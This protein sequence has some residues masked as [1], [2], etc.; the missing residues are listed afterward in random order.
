MP[1]LSVLSELYSSL[2][3]LFYP[4]GPKQENL[5]CWQENV[6]GADDVKHIGSELVG[7]GMKVWRALEMGID[8]KSKGIRGLSEVVRR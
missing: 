8:E 5:G 4:H 3:L 1:W 6:Q 7:K 2:L